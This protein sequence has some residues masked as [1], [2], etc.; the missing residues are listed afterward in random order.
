MNTLYSSN[1]LP[2]E[3]IFT[4]INFSQS[5]I[6]PTCL[7][8]LPLKIKNGSDQDTLGKQPQI[9]TEHVKE[10]LNLNTTLNNQPFAQSSINKHK[11]FCKAQKMV[12]ST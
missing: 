2:K 9:T 1:C 12:K 10:V 11:K 7:G 3:N 6:S 4:S 8:I 5:D